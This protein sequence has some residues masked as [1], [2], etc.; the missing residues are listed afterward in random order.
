[1]ATSDVDQQSLL[2][3]NE[4]ETEDED[5]SSMSLVDHLEELRWRI[6]KSLI[7]IG[8]GT[9][10]AFIFWKQI[11]TFLTIPLPTSANYLYSTAQTKLIATGL[12]EAFSVAL[13]LSIVCGIILAL[14]VILYQV[15]AFISPGLYEREKRHAVPF[16]VLGV[17]LFVIGVALG[18]VVLQYPVN[19]LVNFGSGVFSEMLT[20]GSY[21]TF[22]SFFLLVFG[23]I[24][25]LPLVLTF[26]AIL[27][28]LSADVLKA[29]R[30]IAHVG[31][32]I[33]ATVITPGAD[34]YS[35]IFVGVSLS[36][37]YELSIIF[38]RFFVKPEKEVEA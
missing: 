26:L 4:P 19:W 12:G 28:I 18:Y 36:V 3:T 7:A 21:L 16:I 11:M 10:I 22:V 20:A 5:P 25:E 1:M 37:L 8:V 24:F 31:M 14:P 9:V 27:G 32:W 2:A 6:F 23:L 29:K 30:S 13:K 15:W 17:I 38:I 34:L 33:A 35:P